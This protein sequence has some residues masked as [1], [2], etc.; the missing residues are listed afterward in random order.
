MLF[1]NL[2]RVGSRTMRPDRVICEIWSSN[3]VS[4]CKSLEPFSL[5]DIVRGTRFTV[6]LLGPM[7][8][9]RE[10]HALRM[11]EAFKRTLF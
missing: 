5:L 6:L 10:P 7:L 9:A 11:R 8:E 2:N 4:S 1:N 3:C